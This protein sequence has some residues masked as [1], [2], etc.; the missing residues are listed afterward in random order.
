MKRPWIIMLI[1]YVLGELLWY[2]SGR[3][4]CI[5]TAVFLLFLFILLICRK[6]TK[7]IL[8]NLIISQRKRLE[9]I[10]RLSPVKIKLRQICVLGMVF[11]AA[12]CRLEVM[13]AENEEYRYLSQCADIRGTTEI[14]GRV[15]WIEEKDER[16]KLRI[17]MILVYADAEIAKQ[18]EIGNKISVSG[19]LRNIE[20]ARNPGE[21]DAKSYWRSKGIFFTLRAK[22]IRLKDKST[23]PVLR[24]IYVLRKACRERLEEIFTREAAGFLAAAILGDKTL[25]DEDMYDLYRRNGIA[26]LL[27]IS[28]LHVSLMG[29]ALYKFLRKVVKSGFVSS[30]LLAGAAIALYSIFT[31][32][33]TSV[34]RAGIM[35]ILAFVAEAEGRT[36]DL[37]SA[38]AFAGLIILIHSPAMLFQCGFLLSFTAVIAI[39]GPSEYISKSFGIKDLKLKSLVVSLCVQAFTL[40]L[41]A[42][43]FFSLPIYGFILNL[44]VIPLMGVLLCFAFLSLLLSVFLLPASIFF[45]QLAELILNVYT[46]LCNMFSRLPH[47]YILTGRPALW[48]ILIYYVFVL[49]TIYSACFLYIKIKKKIKRFAEGMKRYKV[50][51]YSFYTILSFSLL[52]ILILGCFFILLPIKENKTEIRFIDVGQGDGIYIRTDEESILIDCGSTTKTEIGK[53]TLKPFLQSLGEKHIDKVFIT[54]ADK[55]HIN[56]L[57]WMFEKDDEIEV[58]SLYLPYPAI[59]DNDYDKIRKAAAYKGIEIQYISEGDYVKPF[60]CLSPRKDCS[61]EDT[62]EQSIVLL[63]REKRFSA[64]FTGD[65][66]KETEKKILENAVYAEGIENLT[67][68]K[69]GHHG[70]HTSSGEEFISRTNPEY[71]VISY[72]EENPYGHPHREVISRLGEYEIETYETAKSG[73]IRFRTDGEKI[74]IEEWIKSGK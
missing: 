13:Q 48:Q 23:H 3:F 74:W 2:I 21:F 29:L 64:L 54:H 39:G 36:Y 50:R 11:L 31:G 14:E 66:G 18:I 47:A 12:S 4:I 71:A 42:Y 60:L 32:A 40:P 56:A 17:G 68:L 9:K 7:R 59:A 37:P 43:F 51:I 20:A 57:L 34:L 55:D 27:A 22:D 65:A 44:I 26:H 24:N 52:S 33:S 67:L 19:R 1:A 25:L 61:L 8:P 35:L 53:F 62:N 6:K 46:V 30:A 49:C 63:Y 28:G 58:G 45:A 10:L 69:L 5:L 72:G 73:Q 15:E 70:S 41:I 38:A 16:C